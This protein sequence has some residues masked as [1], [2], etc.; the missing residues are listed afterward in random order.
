MIIGIFKR[1]TKQNMGY[2]D[3]GA[4]QQCALMDPLSMGHKRRMTTILPYHLK[5]IQASQD[6]QF[7]VEIQTLEQL[8]NQQREF[9]PLAHGNKR[10][11]KTPLMFAVPRQDS[12]K[13]KETQKTTQH[14]MA[15]IS[16]FALLE[17]QSLLRLS[18][19]LRKQLLK[20]NLWQYSKQFSTIPLRYSRNKPFSQL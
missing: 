9:N 5:T 20:L 7:I 6:Q 13:I 15:S 10:Y 1:K 19:I 11:Q 17:S 12:N 3:H 16:N 2:G 4:H 8:M 14:L 18:T